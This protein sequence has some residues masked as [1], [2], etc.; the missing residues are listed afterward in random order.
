MSTA[1][2]IVNPT[3][4]Q[5]AAGKLELTI[6]GSRDAVIMIEAGAKEVSEEVILEALRIGQEN[7]VKVIDLQDKIVAEVGKPKS[8]PSCLAK[9]AQRRNSL[10]EVDA[11]WI[12][13]STL[14]EHHRPWRGQGRAQ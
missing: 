5:I 9:Q 6:A 13:G 14:E 2:S 12:A 7:N 11:N 8:E 3:F 1:S 10:S 4:E